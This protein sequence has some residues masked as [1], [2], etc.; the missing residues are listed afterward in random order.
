VTPRFRRESAIQ[1]DL[2][3]YLRPP[4]P[5]LARQ[6]SE[7]AR[8]GLV[9]VGHS[10]AGRPAAEVLVALEHAVRSVGGEPD[11]SALTEFAEL[12]EAGENPFT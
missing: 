4:V 11:R 1:R 3:T 9:E 2:L 5:Q 7:Q 10:Y 8:P 6:V 12:I